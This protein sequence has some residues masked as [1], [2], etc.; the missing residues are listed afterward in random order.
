MVAFC[1]TGCLF[2]KRD[3]S[4]QKHPPM[5]RNTWSLGNSFCH[6][7]TLLSSRWCRFPDCCSPIHNQP[8]RCCRLLQCDRLDLQGNP[9]DDPDPCIGAGSPRDPRL[10]EWGL[11]GLTSRCGRDPEGNIFFPNDPAEEKN[12]PCLS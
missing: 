9:C 12:P 4:L 10:L 11:A 1:A 7:F 3:K 6:S 2:E 8:L 5:D